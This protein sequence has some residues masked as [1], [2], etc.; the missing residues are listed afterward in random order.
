MK[1]EEEKESAAYYIKVMERS[2]FFKFAGALSAAPL[3]GRLPKW[4]E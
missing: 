2:V 3:K 1:N 4:R